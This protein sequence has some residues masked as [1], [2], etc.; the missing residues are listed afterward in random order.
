MIVEEVPLDN[1][2]EDPE[3]ARLHSDRN[4]DAIVASLKKFGQVEPL[5]V[6]TATMRVVGGNGRLRAMKEMGWGSAR[7]VR[8]DL[9]DTQARALGIALNRT[10]ELAEWDYERLGEVIRTVTEAGIDPLLLGW[11]SYEIEPLLAANWAPPP[12]KP[13]TDFE[14]QIS[15]PKVIKL[16]DEQWVL[17]RQA[18]VILKE[19][20]DG[21]IKDGEILAHICQSFLENAEIPSDDQSEAGDVDELV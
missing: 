8:V 4:I 11:Q 7:I 16:T 17:F 1:L 19:G 14:Q 15:N 9:D 6:Q 13:L 3:N 5:V 10:A 2:S 20:S 12:A 21:T 18:A